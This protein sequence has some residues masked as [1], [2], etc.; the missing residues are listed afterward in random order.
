MDLPF[1][2]KFKDVDVIDSLL[3]SFILMKV[4]KYTYVV[5]IEVVHLVS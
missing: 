1:V 4:D 3:I 2:D 5:Q